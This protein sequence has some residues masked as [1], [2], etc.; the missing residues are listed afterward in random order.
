[1]KRRAALRLRLFANIALES[2]IGADNL[3]DSITHYTCFELFTKE[4]LHLFE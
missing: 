1:M 3:I 4:R 2:A